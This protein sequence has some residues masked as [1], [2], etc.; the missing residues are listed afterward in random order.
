MFPI[1]EKLG[2]RAFVISEWAHYDT[3]NVPTTQTV[4]MWYV[5]KKLPAPA[6]LVLMRMAEVRR[7]EYGSLDFKFRESKKLKTGS[8]AGVQ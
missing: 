6:M 8:A 7:L 4:T 3:E 5:R 2:G 1:I